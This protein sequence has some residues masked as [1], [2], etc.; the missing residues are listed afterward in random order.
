MKNV[1]GLSHLPV[2]S[3]F[4]AMSILSKKHLESRQ[5]S[6]AGVLHQ[7]TYSSCK[8][9]C[10][11]AVCRSCSFVSCVTSKFMDSPVNHI[12]QLSH[13]HMLRYN[14]RGGIRDYSIKSCCSLTALFV[15]LHKHQNLCIELVECSVIW[16]GIVFLMFLLIDTVTNRFLFRISVFISS[17]EE[18]N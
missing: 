7:Q 12:Y 1:R 5:D 10:G 8:I 11:K 15:F 16:S 3:T 4:Y 18:E 2:K 17:V 9:R 13:L 6:L 14:R